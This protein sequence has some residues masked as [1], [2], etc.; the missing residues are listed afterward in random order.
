[1]RY[2][3]IKLTIDCQNLTSSRNM[4]VYVMTIRKRSLI[5]PL[6]NSY[7]SVEFPIFEY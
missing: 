1:M 6:I 3:P 4:Y 2:I 7:L 5:I